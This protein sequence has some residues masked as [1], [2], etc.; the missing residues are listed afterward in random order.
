[1]QKKMIRASRR[2][3][4]PFEYGRELAPEE[5]VD[6]VE[7]VR[8]ATTT[9]VEAGKLFLIGPRRY[10]KTSILHVA[11]RRATASDGAV[12]LRYDA[13]AYP[14]LEALAQRLVADAA[15]ALLGTVERAT[16]R[17][18]QFF[19][20]LRPHLTYN[21]TDGTFSA[22]LNVA[23]RPSGGDVPLITDALD[24][25]ERLA[26]TVDRP[27]AVIID[28]FQQLVESGGRE[29]EGQL[30]SVVQQHAHVGYIFAGSKTHLLA[31]M[32]GDPTRPLYNLGQRR[33][34]GP[35][36]R[37][38]FRAFL[39]RGFQELVPSVDAATVDRVLDVAEEVPYNVQMLAH[40]CWDVLQQ[41][42]PTERHFTPAAVDTAVEQIAR[43]QDGVYTQL[44]MQLTA[45]QQTALIAFVQERGT[46][47]LSAAVARR[48][49]VST[50]SLQTALEALR[51]KSVLRDEESFGTIRLKL[52]DPFFGAWVR[53]FAGV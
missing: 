10:G 16:E 19:G 52:V 48:Y 33:F 15:K 34:L 1:M 31:T 41:Q 53:L 42:P 43:W 9:I 2:S 29:A 25:I 46:A 12:V 18:G 49:G 39:A 50:P 3:R 20:R 27:V 51:T 47:L 22:T 26:S 24:G 35:I 37:E 44:W 6:R 45:L 28:E 4:N 13:E 11:A 17:A 38:D 32:T 7:E 36:P 30:R 14:R 40:T 8:V 23:D 5:L 21:T